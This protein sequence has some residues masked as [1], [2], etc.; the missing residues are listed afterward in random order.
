[1]ILFCFCLI[2][3]KWIRPVSIYRIGRDLLTEVHNLDKNQVG[4]RSIFM[5][6]VRSF[7]Y[8]DF[9]S[10]QSPIYLAHAITELKMSKPVIANTSGL[11]WFCCTRPKCCRREKAPDPRPTR[12]GSLPTTRCPRPETRSWIVAGTLV[13]NSKF[14]KCCTS[15]VGLLRISDH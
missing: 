9:L 7:C 13:T 6:R 12:T 4:T 3:Y 5:L 1:M 11:T 15:V 8:L 10:S 14:A 2:A